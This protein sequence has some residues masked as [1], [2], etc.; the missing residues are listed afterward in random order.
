MCTLFTT[1][2]KKYVNVGKKQLFDMQ[3][4]KGIVFSEN[5]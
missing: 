5:N 2:V 1:A 4:V 3:Q